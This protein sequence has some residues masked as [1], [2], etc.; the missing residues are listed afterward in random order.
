MVN[1]FTTNSAAGGASAGSDVGSQL[2]EDAGRLKNTVMEQGEAKVSQSK[3][4]ATKS[5]RSASSALNAVADQLR[6][7]QNGPAWLASALSSA[8]QQVESFA[9]SVESSSPQDMAN[10]IKRFAR[11]SPTA[12]LAA[13]AVVGFAAARF[14][15]AGAEYH[16]EHD[17]HSSATG[18]SSG[19][20]AY[21][22]SQQGYGER[23]TGSFQPQQVST[24]T[25]S[26][27]QV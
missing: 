9:G 2:K 25:F 15:R 13:S 17:Q 1:D 11:Q 20:S 6:N 5:A 27:D 19:Y 12:F 7:D 14:L 22:Q 21:G 4:Q 26:G 8:A 18:A 10:Q 24:S 3:E 16:E 23:Q